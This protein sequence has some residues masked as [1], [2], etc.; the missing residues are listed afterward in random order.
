MGVM[1][2]FATNRK[3][4]IEGL[5]VVFDVNPDGT[6]PTI[7]IKRVWRES[8][9]YQA[10][11]ERVTRPYK[12]I[13]DS[14]TQELDE[15]IDAK[16][17]QR[18]FA[19]ASVSGWANMRLPEGV[20]DI[21][22]G[23]GEIYFDNRAEDEHALSLEAFQSCNGR[24]YDIEYSVDACCKLFNLLPDMWRKLAG[25]AGDGDAYKVGELE[26]MTKNS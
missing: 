4:E 8:P 11:F 20:A 23:E 18:V 22:K 16:L 9:R 19:E 26:D 25:M 6:K 17:M 24:D 14:K 13:I 3:L 2:Q 10:I 7:Y 12:D 1:K 5:P 21:G 15:A